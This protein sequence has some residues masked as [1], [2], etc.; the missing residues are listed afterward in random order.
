MRESDLVDAELTLLGRLPDASNTALLTDLRA[1]DGRRRYGLY[2]PIRGE[3][4]LWD[5]PDGFLAHREVAAYLISQA[6]GWQVVPPT[7]LRDGP[8]GVGSVQLWVTATPAEDGTPQ[9]D[10]RSLRPVPSEVDV[11]VTTSRRLPAGYLPVLTGQRSAGSRVV[12]A[13]ADTPEL[14]SV[15]VFDAV[16][17]NS[18]RK[19]SHLLRDAGNRLWGVDHG[20]SLHAQDKLRTVL[21]GWRG[22][23]L[24]AADVQRLQILRAALGGQT[25][26]GCEQSGLVAAL[27]ELLTRAEV[28]AVQRR[29]EHLLSTGVFPEPPHE[30]P[31]VPWPPL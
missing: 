6:G 3:R 17:N 12:I 7:A 18:D 23:P 26:P 21:W 16:L 2:K 19:A 15:A 4:P 22:Q 31:A 13:H 20:V 8:L 5:F 11:I 29:V 14:A 9:V 1:A 30:W 27:A 25:G 10:P 28:A 24:P